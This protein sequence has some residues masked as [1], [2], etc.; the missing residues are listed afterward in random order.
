ML[1]IY[2]RVGGAQGIWAGSARSGRSASATRTG[3]SNIASAGR[4]LAMGI[5]SVGIDQGRVR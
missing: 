3:S 1:E 4:V 5:R 2:T